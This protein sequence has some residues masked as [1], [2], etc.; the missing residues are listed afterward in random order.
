[1]H[2]GASDGEGDGDVDWDGLTQAVVDSAQPS[3]VP[4][5]RSPGEDPDHSD[6]FE[7]DDDDNWEGGDDVLPMDSIG[8]SYTKEAQDVRPIPGRPQTSPNPEGGR[9]HSA[10]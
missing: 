4:S 9:P 2:C 10:V 3:P 7:D 8:S 1:V 5:P 6:D